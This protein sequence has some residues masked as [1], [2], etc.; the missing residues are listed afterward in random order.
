MTIKNLT[1]LLNETFGTNIPYYK[2]ADKL[3]T[4]GAWDSLVT[5]SFE[6][7]IDTLVGNTDM[8]MD[9]ADFFQEEFF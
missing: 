5:D 6:D 9:E 1:G 3:K 4:F 8:D 7:Y 2:I